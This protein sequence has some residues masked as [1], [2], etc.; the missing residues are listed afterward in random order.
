M[1]AKLILKLKDLPNS[2]QENI[3]IRK[4]FQGKGDI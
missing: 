3:N 4:V 2:L 1:E